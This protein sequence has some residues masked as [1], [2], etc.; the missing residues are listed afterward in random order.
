[1]FRIQLPGLRTETLKFLLSHVD[2]LRLCWTTDKLLRVS[3]LFRG[4]GKD[5]I[6]VILILRYQLEL[7]DDYIARTNKLLEEERKNKGN[8]GAWLILV[9]I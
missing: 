3:G 9:L 1:M 8:M 6:V 2:N 7:K 4:D 5:L